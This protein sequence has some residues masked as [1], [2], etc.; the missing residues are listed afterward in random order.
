M[1]GI[2]NSILNGAQPISSVYCWFAKRVCFLSFWPRKTNDSIWYASAAHVAICKPVYMCVLSD[3]VP[4]SDGV[5]GSSTGCRKDKIPGWVG[6]RQGPLCPPPQAYGEE[7]RGVLS[8]QHKAGW[9]CTPLPPAFFF[10]FPLCFTF[11]RLAELCECTPAV[12]SSPREQISPYTMLNICMYCMCLR[13]SVF[14]R[15]ESQVEN[16][17]LSPELNIWAGRVEER[18]SVYEYISGVQQ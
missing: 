18:G 2:F 6:C 12:P 4:G 8:G 14:R 7:R 11:S 13:E 16:N 5:S 9:V 3:Q 10:T 17:C 1:N 15:V